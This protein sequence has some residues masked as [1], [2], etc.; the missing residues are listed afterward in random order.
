[1]KRNIIISLILIGL[2]AFGAGFGTYAWFTSQA[3]SGNNEFK[4]GTIKLKELGE[5]DFKLGAIDNMAPG[6]VT[7]VATIEIK[8]IG[9]LDLA[10]FGHF[11]FS[12]DEEL[13][14]ALYIDYAKMEFF[15][16]G[17]LDE[18]ATD[19]FIV[20]GEPSGQYAAGWQP[21]VDEEKGVVTL[22]KFLAYNAMGPG[23]GYQAGALIPGNSCK[24]SIKLG[25]LPTAGNEYQGKS[26]NIKYIV[27]A[28][29]INQGALTAYGM[30]PDGG[31]YLRWLLR[32]IDEQRN[33]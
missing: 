13:K 31:Q 9:T 8:N 14:E 10:W 22:N 17:I 11:A 16:D 12:G 19:E 18:A 30:P 21:A 23:P 7:D 4:S 3:V 15:E 26:L 33:N 20:N 5:S 29:Q 1:M 2:L 25:F 6:D 24:F 28:T 27:D 32:L